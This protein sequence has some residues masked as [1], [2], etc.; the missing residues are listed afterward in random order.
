MTDKLALL[1]GQPVI[2]N[3]IDFE[4]HDFGTDDI[5]AVSKVIQSGE[6]GLGPEVKAF[7]NEYANRYGIKYGISV[8][9]GTSALHTCVAA[10]NPSP[11][12]EIITTAWTSG[13]SIIGLLFQNC[14]PIFADIDDSYCL[15]PL[16]VER[17]ITP[18][19]K[20][21]LVVNLMGN[22]ADVRKLREIADRH[23]IFLIEDCC[24][25]HFAEDNGIVA[26]SIADISGF[27]FGGKHLNLGG[28]GMVLT[29]NKALWERAILFRDAALPRDG[30]PAEGKPYANQFLAPNYKMNDIMAAMGR[31]QLKKVDGY[32]ESKIKSAKIIIDGLS[33]IKEITPQKVRAG[34]THTYWLLSFTIDTNAL[35]CTATEYA[36]AVS[37]E[38]IP[39]TGPYLLTPKIGPLSKNPFLSKP[40]LYGESKFPLDYNRENQVNYN[41]TKLPYGNQ[42]MSRN[43][44]FIMTPNYSDNYIEKVIEAHHK[45]I[46]HYR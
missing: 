12:D 36:E 33:N 9:S 34:V 42:L 40:D 16:D 41:E 13:G 19:T 15:D 5:D 30:G 7:E 6:I 4:G 27:S 31:T 3:P 26:G 1:G 14:V 24:Q 29:N 11:G 46:N 25:S 10:M 22:M 38:G 2:S 35:H 37:A 32:V 20:A 28:G 21:I 8:N 45:V 44:N 17:K 23:N 39:T 18:R 43:V